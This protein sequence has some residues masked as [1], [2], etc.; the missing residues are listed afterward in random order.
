MTR[1]AA[2]VSAVEVRPSPGAASAIVVDSPHSGFG[3]PEDFAP[4][5]PLDALRTTWD[6]HVEA[7]WG[8]APSAGAT[9]L[10]ATFPRC[11]IDVNRAEGDLDAALLADAWDG[12]LAPTDYSRRGMGLIRRDALPG[13]PMYGAPLSAAAV[14]TRIDR[15]YRPYRAALA[16]AIAEG[17]R[18]HG[19]VWHLNCH[20]MKSRGNAMNV[21]AGATRPDV[22]VSDRRGTTADP[23]LTARIAA[24]FSARG[25]RTQ[26]NEPYQGGDLVR[27]FGAPTVGVQS[28]QIEFNRSRYMD[29]ATCEPHEGFAALRDD[30]TALVA[31][32]VAWRDEWSAERR[33]AAVRA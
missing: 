20:S 8:G 12:P 18:V 33:D 25:Y 5:A 15:W 16:G 7:L 4:A 6:A 23:A 1:P 26:V 30:C 31:A 3:F 27:T 29:E 22:V 19:A 21:D 28:V 13:V 2:S 32:M 9:L 24:W 17:Q 10:A 11:Y 14:R